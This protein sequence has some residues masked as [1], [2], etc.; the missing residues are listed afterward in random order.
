MLAD[1]RLYN[2]RDGASLVG[3]PAGQDVLCRHM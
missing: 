3:R 2:V 1:S